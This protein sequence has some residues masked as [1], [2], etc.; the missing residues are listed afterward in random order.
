MSE[1]FASSASYHYYYPLQSLSNLHDYLLRK[2]CRGTYA[3]EC[4]QKVQITKT[5][6]SLD[7]DF[8]SVSQAIDIRAFSSNAAENT[9]WEEQIEGIGDSRIEIGILSSQLSQETGKQSMRGILVVL[10]EDNRFSE[11]SSSI[12]QS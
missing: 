9:S 5:A 4:S 11:Y 12:D 8:D 7:I 2:A 10:G 3:R 6:D 1:R